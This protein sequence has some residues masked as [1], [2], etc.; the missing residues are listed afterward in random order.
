MVVSLLTERQH[1]TLAVVYSSLFGG[2]MVPAKS[3]FLFV[4]FSILCGFVAIY[5][6]ASEKVLDLV[7]DDAR[8]HVSILPQ[9]HQLPIHADRATQVHLAQASKDG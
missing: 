8:G 9:S 4:I 3:A 1:G 5:P 6:V 7:G 2:M